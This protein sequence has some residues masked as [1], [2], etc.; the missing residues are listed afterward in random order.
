MI[1][2]K[3]SKKERFV[4]K[5]FQLLPWYTRVLQKHN[6]IPTLPRTLGQRF[7]SLSYK[8]VTII[9]WDSVSLTLEEI[10]PPESIMMPNVRAPNFCGSYIGS[11]TIRAVQV[12]MCWY[13]KMEDQHCHTSLFRYLTK[14][15]IGG[16]WK[17]A[18]SFYYS[19]CTAFQPRAFLLFF[20]NAHKKWGETAYW[21]SCKE[22]EDREN[23]LTQKPVGVLLQH[24]AK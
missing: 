16:W 17:K 3:T 6:I 13:H 10:V 11:C 21:S 22:A 8:M 14:A 15:R 24:A 2:A 19:L 4:G 9:T 23:S 18:H 5:T 12:G 20:W 1:V 7:Q